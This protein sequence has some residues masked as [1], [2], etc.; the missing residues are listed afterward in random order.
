M[1]SVRSRMIPR[2]VSGPRTSIGVRPRP[3][4]SAP[5]DGREATATGADRA[6]RGTG[7]ACDGEEEQGSGNGVA[8]HVTHEDPPDGWEVRREAIRKG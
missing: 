7:V 6:G 5:P 4:R 8:R 3:T 2:S 1:I